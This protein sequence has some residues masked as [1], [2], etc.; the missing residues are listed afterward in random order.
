MLNVQNEI[1]RLNGLTVSQLQAEYERVTGEAARSS[2]RVFLVKRIVWRMQA[3][4]YGG[5]SERARQRAAELARESDLRVRPRPDIHAAFAA[6]TGEA[7]STRDRG[8]PLPGSIL[9]REYR[10]R[11]IEVK[12]LDRGFEYGGVAYR[13][14]TAVAKAVTGSDWNG[15]LFFGLT[16]RSEVA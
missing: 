11:R 10:G 15:R 3:A 16:N 6:A 5:L 14:L 7:G 9:T 1:K 13:S 8:L 12:V 2:N 4:A